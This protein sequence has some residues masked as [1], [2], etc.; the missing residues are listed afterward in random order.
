MAQWRERPGDTKPVVVAPAGEAP[1]A[2]GGAEAPGQDAVP[3]TAAQHPPTAISRLPRTP[4]HRSSVVAAV[5]AVLH[6]LPYVPVHVM[7]PKRI[8]RERAHR[9]RPTA[10]T[11]SAYIAARTVPPNPVSPP[12]P[13]PRPRPRHV[14][15]LRLAQE[16]VLL[17]R[18][19]RQPRHIPLR[20]PATHVD[21]R[22]PPP[23]PARVVRTIP[24]TASPDTHAS[25]SPNVTSYTPTA[26][27]RANVTRCTGPSS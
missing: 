24:P 6:P 21:D 16:P 7:Q 2:A 10:V 26:N 3:R 5:P 4:I 12:I 18:L 25:H 13:R 8:R 19:P 9:R 1:F 15:P 17:P 22:A 14:L 27:G 11:A 23:A 20:I